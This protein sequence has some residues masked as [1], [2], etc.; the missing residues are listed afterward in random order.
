[1]KEKTC[2]WKILQLGKHNFRIINELATRRKEKGIL[3]GV[4]C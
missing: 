4:V 1:M 3:V 2:T